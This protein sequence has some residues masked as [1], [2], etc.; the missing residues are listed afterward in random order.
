MQAMGA[1][2]VG[3]VLEGIKAV[4]EKREVAAQHGKVPPEL[5]V[6]DS[7]RALL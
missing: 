2:A 1:G 3:V 6:R 7:T 4:L 5:V